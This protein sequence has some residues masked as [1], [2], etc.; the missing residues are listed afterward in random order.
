MQ[1][2]AASSINYLSN[3][4]N[5]LFQNREDVLQK[6]NG[7]D[8]RVSSPNVHLSENALAMSNRLKQNSV[9]ILDRVNNDP[10]YAEKAA[11]NFSSSSDLQL[12]PFNL[13]DTLGSPGNKMTAAQQD[14]FSSGKHEEDQQYFSSQASIA[15]QQRHAIYSDMKATGASGKEIFYAIMDYNNSLPDKYKEMA[16]LTQLSA[17]AVA[18]LKNQSKV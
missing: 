10:V 14:Y 1:I 17:A 16:G 7:A 4:K 15:S 18:E 3:L 13:Y 12:S 2:N 9:S 11:K 5:S 8:S 6:Q